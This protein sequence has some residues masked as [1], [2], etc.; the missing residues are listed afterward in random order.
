MWLYLLFL[1]SVGAYLLADID[2][3]KDSAKVNN[4]RK[5]KFIGV[6]RRTPSQHAIEIIV[7]N[8][9]ANATQNNAGFLIAKSFVGLCKANK[10]TKPKVTNSCPCKEKCKHLR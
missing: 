2:N 10:A 5:M 6:L 8:K 7:T 4:P 1:T 3:K 9:T